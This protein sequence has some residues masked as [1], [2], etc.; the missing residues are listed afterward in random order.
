MTDHPS[1]Y[2]GRTLETGEFAWDDRASLHRADDGDGLFDAMKA[3][4]RGTFAEMIRHIVAL[5]EAE[6]GDY[7]IQK[8]GDRKYSAGEAED[9]AS[10]SDFP[11]A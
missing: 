2:K 4:R 1:T 9:L 5:P 7:V 3:V 8:A 10:R 11:A 6:R